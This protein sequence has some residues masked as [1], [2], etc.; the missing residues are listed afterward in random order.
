MDAEEDRCAEARKLQRIDDAFHRGDL[1]ALRAAVDDPSTIP[2]GRMPDTVG[3]CLVYAI[4]HSPLPFIRA[5][6]E[7]G[8]RPEQT[9]RRRI[10]ATHCGI[11]LRA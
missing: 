7:M 8:A 1:E 3:S 6:L 9:S 5:L 11:D 4:Y 2:N 10:P